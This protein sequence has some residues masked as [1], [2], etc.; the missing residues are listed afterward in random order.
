MV[1]IVKT[2]Q[3]TEEN[4]IFKILGDNKLLFWRLVEQ[5]L[6]LINYKHCFIFG[7]Q[8]NLV[9][10]NCS[11]AA[12]LVSCQYCPARW[13]LIAPNSAHVLPTCIK[14]NSKSS[15]KLRCERSTPPPHHFHPHHQRFRPSRA[16]L[17]S[18]LTCILL[19]RDSLT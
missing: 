4:R 15:F 12:V 7:W 13:G 10:H 19:M 3:Q 11:E 6:L 5:I 16:A 14:T 8:L 18:P 2:S 1:S 9:K 17:A